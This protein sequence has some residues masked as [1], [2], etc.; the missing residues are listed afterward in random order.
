MD[1]GPSWRWGERGEWG[2]AGSESEVAD[3]SR[4]FGKKRRAEVG[5]TA[6]PG[7]PCLGE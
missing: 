4:P 7:E 5:D 1:A 3:A 2:D 6:E